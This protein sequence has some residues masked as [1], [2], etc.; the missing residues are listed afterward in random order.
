L[1]FNE[2]DL[3]KTPPPPTVRPSPKVPNMIFL[4]ELR[5]TFDSVMRTEESIERRAGNLVTVSGTIATLLF[6]FR[7][8]LLSNVDPQF[9]LR[10]YMFYTLAFG[11]F[12]ALIS[13]LS[14]LL[15]GYSRKGQ[16]LFA[17][18]HGPFFDKN[19]R[20]DGDRLEELQSVSVEKFSLFAA[21]QYLKAI[22]KNNQINARRS[23]NLQYSQWALFASVVLIMGLGVLLGMAL[24]ENMIVIR[25]PLVNLQ[26]ITIIILYNGLFV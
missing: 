12:A 4:E 3:P 2:Y 8:Y 21:F 26:T 15:T 20:V 10:N 19:G 18:S 24:M 11:I 14:S 23:L 9:P 1:S 17:M 16:Y 7:S 5:K 13:L 22:E 6:V 25:S